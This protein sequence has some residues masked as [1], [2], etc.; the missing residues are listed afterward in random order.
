MGPE[1]WKRSL[2]QA[3]FPVTIY[4]GN[5]ADCRDV[6]ETLVLDRMEAFLEGLGI[7]KLPD[8]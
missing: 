7:S 1:D 8:Y 3:G 2:Q 6:D 5:F 4:E